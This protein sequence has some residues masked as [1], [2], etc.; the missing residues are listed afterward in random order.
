MFCIISIVKPSPVIETVEDALMPQSKSKLDELNKNSDNMILDEIDS[1]QELDQ[2][3]VPYNKFV[4]PSYY[5]EALLNKLAE[6]E[7]QEEHLNDMAEE[8]QPSSLE[9]RSKNVL[10]K[11]DSNSEQRNNLRRQ[12]AAR[13]DIGFGKRANGHKSKSFMDALYGKRSHKNLSPKVSFGRKQ[14]WDIQ[15]G[16]K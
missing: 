16:K 3:R 13:W 5:I 2:Q 1:E 10:A 4:I 11:K 6:L 9:K 7:E 12:Q 15:Y 8:M 14:M